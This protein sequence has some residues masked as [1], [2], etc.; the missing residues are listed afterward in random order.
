[1]DIAK[2][3][4]MSQPS[5]CYALTRATD[6]LR[7]VIERPFL[8]PLVMRRDLAVVFESGDVDVLM[9]FWRT[10]CQMVMLKNLDQAWAA[11]YVK[12]FE[13]LI[14]AGIVLHHIERS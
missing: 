4:G 9:S 1:V 11:K 2:L 6:R 5:V 14:S 8:D 13:S 12:A 10:G 7:Y 3:M